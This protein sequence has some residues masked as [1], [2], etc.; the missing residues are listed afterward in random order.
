MTEQLAASGGARE[1]RAEAS[2]PSAE[3]RSALYR[4]YAAELRKLAGLKPAGAV[5]DQ[6]MTLAR[7]YEVLARSVGEAT[8]AWPEYGRRI[9][10]LEPAD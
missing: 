3:A 8:E 4:R 7:Q 1:R 10:V 5:R 2:V 9:G 6:L